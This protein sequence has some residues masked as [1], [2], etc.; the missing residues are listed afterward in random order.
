M[1]S[2][3]GKSKYSISVVLDREFGLRLRQ[4]LEAGPVWVV[5]SPTNRDSAEKIWAEFPE[6]D[7]LDGVTVFKSA[8]TRDPAEILTGELPAIDLHH[9]VHSA[10]PAYAAIRVIGCELKPD[11]QE[12][13][14]GFGFDSFTRT[15]EGFEAIRPLPPPLGR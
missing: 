7:H 2:A 5:D 10:D 15:P 3:M 1:L 8:A 12:V 4:L 6:R 14:A 11:V 9:G 13:L